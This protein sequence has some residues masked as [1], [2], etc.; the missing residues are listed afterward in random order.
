MFL[1][2][3]KAP[4]FPI[5]ADR[6]TYSLSITLIEKGVDQVQAVSLQLDP[7]VLS[8]NIEVFSH[9]NYYLGLKANN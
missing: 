5:I 6:L 2:K 4:D 3:F 7:S 1:V 9:P 8:T